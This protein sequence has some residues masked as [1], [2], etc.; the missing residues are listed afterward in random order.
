MPPCSA[1][2]ILKHDAT[3]PSILLSNYD[4]EFENKM[5]HSIYDSAHFHKYNYT[6]GSGQR[7]VRLNE[8][9]DI[10]RIRVIFVEFCY[11]Q[12]NSGDSI[13]QRGWDGSWC[14]NL[15]CFR[16]LAKVNWTAVFHSSVHGGFQWNVEIS[17]GSKPWWETATAELGESL[18]EEIIR[19]RNKISLP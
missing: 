9:C 3:V 13:S 7:V 19:S 4:K 12:K 1:K 17:G 14:S 10:V 6:R 11:W 18:S 5:F 8:C 2:S 15:S 16:G